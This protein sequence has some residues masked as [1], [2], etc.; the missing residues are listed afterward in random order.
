M[1]L[2]ILTSEKHKHIEKMPFNQKMIE[3][4]LTREE[5][6]NYLTQVYNIFD[7]IERK[8]ELPE[9]LIRTR[10]VLSDIYELDVN[11]D[12]KV[13]SSTEQYITHLNQQE[14]YNIWPHVYLNYMAF[15]FGG[16]L[17][18]PNILGS[19]RVY[20][21]DNI[22]ESVGFIRKIQSDEWADEVNRGFDFLI[23]IYGQ[24]QGEN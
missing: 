8:V 3:G 20:D 15:M 22:Q 16:Q 2:K 14:D 5:Y 17:I 23:S 19:G 4:K 21:F 9:N 24:L 18:K 1:S 13:L 6:L 10:N 11:H 12:F 7:T